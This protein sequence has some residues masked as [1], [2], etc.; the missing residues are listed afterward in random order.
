MNRT[1]RKRTLL[2]ALAL[3]ALGLSG[4]SQAQS[5]PARAVK[6]VIPTPPSGALDILGRQ[7]AEKLAPQ[8]SHPVVVENRPGTAMIVA[9]EAVARAP[10]DGYTILFTSDATVTINPHLIAKLP[11]DVK[12]LA[13]VS[14][15]VLVEL[16]MYGHPSVP[17]SLRELVALA[18]SKPGTINYASYG[19]GSEPHLAME[20]LKSVAGISLVH[21]PYKGGAQVIQSL[22]AGEV[23]IAV[24]SIPTVEPHLKA[25]RAVALA[26]GGAQRSP[27]LPDVPT[28]AE[29][30]YGEVNAYGGFSLFVPVGT[31]R[32]VIGRIYGDAVRVLN[33][34]Q[35]IEK[36]IVAKGFKPVGSAPDEFAAYLRKDSE[37]RAKAIKLA[38]AG[39]Q[40][41][42]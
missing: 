24:T 21:V 13:P 28:F 3:V 32:E 23:Q 8:W 11:Y 33:E 37:S 42:Q 5:W 2:G 25:R 40:T 34:P 9:A 38:G 20:M 31:P 12:D 14:Q 41:S 15:I 22:I 17:G 10:A 19:I 29:L 1:G 6:L 36:N 39:S 18:R 35:F 7:L 27:V 16:L 26:F 4:L 30:G